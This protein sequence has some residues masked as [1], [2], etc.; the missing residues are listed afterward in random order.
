M[1]KMGL[2]IT[3]RFT[4]ARLFSFSTAP[5]GLLGEFRT[6]A[7]V[8]EVMA[9]FRV[10]SSIWKPE[11]AISRGTIFAPAMVMMLS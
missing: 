9:A 2:P 1:T 6:I 10:A 11:A 7:L 8:L 5:V 3:A 4:A